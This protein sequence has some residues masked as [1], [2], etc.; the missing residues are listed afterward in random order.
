MNLSMVLFICL[1]QAE[2]LLYALEI[3]LVVKC[4]VV[5]CGEGGGQPGIKMQQCHASS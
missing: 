3:L 1:A 4:G 5:K 2:N